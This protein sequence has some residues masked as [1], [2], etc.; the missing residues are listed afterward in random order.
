MVRESLQ[1]T[2][3][4]VRGRLLDFPEALC[5]AVADCGQ[6]RVLG[7]QARGAVSRP[8]DECG[9]VDLRFP[10]STILPSAASPADAT[11][12]RPLRVVVLDLALQRHSRHEVLVQSQHRR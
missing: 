2:A 5:I 7:R 12:V 3:L 6:L 8:A 11:H 4:A 9:I 10:V 1:L